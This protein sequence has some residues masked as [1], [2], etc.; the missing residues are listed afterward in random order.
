MK[1]D[2][3]FKKLAKFRDKADRYHAEA[4]VIAKNKSPKEAEEPERKAQDFEA[5][6]ITVCDKL[7][8]LSDELKVS[9]QQMRLSGDTGGADKVHLRIVSIKQKINEILTNLAAP[10]R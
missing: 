7:S 10:P 5:E 8:T 6:I 9:E 1:E 3:Y 2:R 4:E